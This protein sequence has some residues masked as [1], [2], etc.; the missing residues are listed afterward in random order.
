MT[1]RVED[2]YVIGGQVLGTGT[3]GD[4][5]LGTNRYTGAKVAVK[6]LALQG[7]CEMKRRGSSTRSR[8]I[9][10]W[11]IPTSLVSSRSTRRR[12]S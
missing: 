4:V 1:R 8:S 11:I 7:L 2:D 10:V 5:V 12:T 3:N 6:S 9:S